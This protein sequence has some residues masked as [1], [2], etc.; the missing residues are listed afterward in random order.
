MASPYVKE[1]DVRASRIVK[2]SPEPTMTSKPRG[3]LGLRLLGVLLIAVAVAGFFLPKPTKT[4]T[5]SSAED[6]RIPAS[7][8][9]SG[10]AEQRG[11]PMSLN[12]DY[13]MTMTFSSAGSSVSYPALV[14][15]T[16][17]STAGP[18]LRRVGC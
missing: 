6:S 4:I 10:Q 1:I 9:Y 3:L 16:S 12:K 14:R 13:S 2:E 5:A 7:G 17:R 11:K 8:T 15:G 18:R